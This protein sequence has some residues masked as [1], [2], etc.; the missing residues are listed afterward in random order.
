MATTAQHNAARNDTDLLARLIAAAEKAGVPNAQQWVE[1]NRGAL[2][3]ADID[4]STLADVHAYAV[5]TYDPTPRPG[6]DAAKITD[7]QLTAAIEA[8]TL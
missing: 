8:T 1:T 3:A 4:G 5:A 6:E 2:V 7:V